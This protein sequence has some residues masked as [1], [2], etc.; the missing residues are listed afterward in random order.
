MFNREAAELYW[1]LSIIAGM[2]KHLPE[3]DPRGAKALFVANKMINTCFTD[4]PSTY[5]PALQIGKEFLSE[6]N[7]ESSFRVSAIGHCHI[8]STQFLFSKSFL[9]SNFFSP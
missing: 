3:N 4:D 9:F 2:A 1:D 5:A 8:G 7:S 6:K